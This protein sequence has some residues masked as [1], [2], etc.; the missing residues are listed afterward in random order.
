M[1]AKKIQ[2]RLRTHRPQPPFTTFVSLNDEAGETILCFPALVE[3]RDTVVGPFVIDRPVSIDIVTGDADARVDA[4]IEPFYSAGSRWLWARQDWRERAGAMRALLHP[5]DA[6][7]GQ[8]VPWKFRPLGAARPSVSLVIPTRDGLAVLER[9]VA[10]LFENARWPDKELIIVDNGSQEA[11]TL[12]YLR[13]LAA[14]PAIKIIREDAPFN[15]ARLNN[16][17]ARAARGDILALMN[18]DIETDDPD[19]L[20]AFVA[21]ASDPAVGAVGGK[22]LFPDGTVQHAGVTLGVRGYVAHVGLGRAGDDEGPNRILA[23]TRRVSAVTGA[24][25]FTPRALYQRLGGFDENYVIEFNDI[26]YCLRVGEAGLAVVWAAE[27]R[28][29]HKE[30]ATRGQRPLREQ[31]LLD[32]KR[33]VRH[34]GYKLTGDPYYPHNLT[35][36]DESLRRKLPFGL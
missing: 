29:L 21:L 4:T 16:I 8:L 28:L 6:R 14:N 32:R 34:W 33:F 12:A 1:T 19:W 10:T 2:V 30:S 11:D 5:K 24:C 22:L 23:T 20:D 18:N 7:A 3:A 26:D 25:L 9:A 36:R 15:F 35:L 31:E 17:G 13:A 27:P